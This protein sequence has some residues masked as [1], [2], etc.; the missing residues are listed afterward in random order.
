DIDGDGISNESD[1]FD[2]DADNGRGTSLPHR[3]A[4]SGEVIGMLGGMTAYNAPGFTG[5]MA[6]PDDQVSVLDQFNPDRLIPGGAAGIFTVEEVTAGDARFNTQENAF[7]FGV[8]V[9]GASDVF[10]ARTRIM[11]PFANATPQDNQSMGMVI[12]RGDQDNYIKLVTHANGGAGGIKFAREI[13]GEFDGQQAGAAILGADFVDLYLVVNPA[14][15]TVEASYVIVRDGIRDPRTVVGEAIQMPSD[16][17]SDAINGLAVGIISTTG[18]AAVFPASWGFVEVYEGTGEAFPVPGEGQLDADPPVL[19]FPET[20]IDVTA[21]RTVTLRNTGEAALEISDADMT[22]DD[23]F[24]AESA[25]PRTLEPGATYDF[26]VSFTP[27]VASGFEA[28]LALS[29]DGPNSPLQI[30]VTG[31]GTSVLKPDPAQ[32]DFGGVVVG[33]STSQS[34]SLANTS[35]AP[36]LLGNLGIGSRDANEFDLAAATDD[37]SGVTLGPG[38]TCSFAVA[39]QPAATGMRSA[40]VEIPSNVGTVILLL[41]GR[42]RIALDLYIDAT[43]NPAVAGNP[44]TYAMVVSNLASVRA[45]NVTLTT[46]L[47]AGTALADTQGCEQ[48]PAGHPA[49]TI[50][51]IDGNE[52]AEVF[53]IVDVSTS[54]TGS[55]RFGASANADHAAGTIVKEATTS[56]SQMADLALVMTGGAVPV[57]DEA[58]ALLYVIVVSNAGPSDAISALVM[59][60]LAPG[61]ENVD[62]TCEA[63]IGAACAGSGEGEIDDLADLPAGTSVTYQVE[64]TA[65]RALIEEGVTSS[66]EVSPSGDL[67]DPD[68]DNNRDSVT[69]VERLFHD[70]FEADD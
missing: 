5:L 38:E 18:G 51:S 9:D 55:L 31:D 7:H 13:Q 56:I 23:V 10:T 12:G 28:V 58:M 11:A 45:D 48:D 41:E 32:V 21:T 61:L 39:F 37:C 36:V 40:Q 14:T 60:E 62:W 70:R 69:I 43:P 17:L 59:T 16:W 30:P 64:A 63:D 53:I 67:A 65:P 47:P 19:V 25:L 44:L 4:W 6:N 8:D 49:C 52:S 33:S 3:L 15:A 2:F 26:T 68:L 57:D 46:T 20:L 35:G 54:A 1:R 29:H 22:G 50:G 42:G 66:A 27:D 24:V 34:I